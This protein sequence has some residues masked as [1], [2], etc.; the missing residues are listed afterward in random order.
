MAEMLLKSINKEMKDF[1]VFKDVSA[2]DQEFLKK[3][4]ADS[5]VRSRTDNSTHNQ[6]S[7]VSKNVFD[8]T[9]EV[10]VK[11]FNDGAFPAYEQEEK[12]S[13]S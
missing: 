13:T 6:K 1:R 4:A 3:T 10:K 11:P 2:M 5:V 8:E 7:C 12:R 9:S